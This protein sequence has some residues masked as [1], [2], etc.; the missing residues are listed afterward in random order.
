MTGNR[1][2]FVTGAPEKYAHLVDRLSAAPDRLRNVVAGRSPSELRRAPEDGNWSAAR[3]LAHL[4]VVTQR[5][6]TFVY[7]MGTMTDPA[8]NPFVESDESERLQHANPESLLT[9]FEAAV[10]EVVAF[11]S[12]T[13]DAAWGRPGRKNGLRRSLRQEVVTMGDHFD[14]HIA[15]LQRL[16]S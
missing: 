10:G 12:H 15:E 5:N 2:D 6:G 7:Q 16:L 14:E 11:L 8:R 9:A 1:I 4:V 3:I 13:P